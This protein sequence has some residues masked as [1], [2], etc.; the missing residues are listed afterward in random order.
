VKN[1][2]SKR[3]IEEL[4]SIKTDSLA[5]KEAM[6]AKLPALSLAP[7]VG[8]YYATFLAERVEFTD[9]YIEYEFSPVSLKLMRPRNVHKEFIKQIDT[10]FA[11]ADLS[12]E[13][14]AL[15]MIIDEN[16]INV[17]LGM[18]LKIDTMYSLRELLAVDPRLIMMRQLLTTTTVGMAITSFKQEYGEGRPIDLVLTSS[19]EFMTTGLGKV[20]PTGVSIDANGNYQGLM[21]VGAQIIVTNKEGKQ[22]EARALYIQFQL[23]GKMFVAD[24]QHDNRTLVIMP[25]SV[26]MPIFKVMNSQGDE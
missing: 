12:E 3:L 14:A 8:L 11:E 10:K 25:K 2:L 5:G 23:K 9:S 18:F 15:Q 19:H 6:I 22:V 21:N 4:H 20:N 17:V 1:W 13:P 7:V 26:N 24:A 16:L